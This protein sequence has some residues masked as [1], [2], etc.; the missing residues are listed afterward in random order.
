MLL[1]FLTPKDTCLPVP[2][3][4]ARGDRQGRLGKSLS[5]G[6]SSGGGPRGEASA[7]SGTGQPGKT[8]PSWGLPQASTGATTGL[9]DADLRL[10]LSS[11]GKGG[12]RASPP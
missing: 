1:P 9:G 4:L 3:S 8:A 5:L 7:R 2:S 10:R 12:T 6:Q 11:E